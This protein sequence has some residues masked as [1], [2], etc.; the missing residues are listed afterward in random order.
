MKQILGILL[1]VLAVYLGY[2]GITAFQEST[3]EL[4]LFGLEIN[5]TD[6]SGKQTSI[7]YLVLAVVSAVGGIMLM[8]G[9]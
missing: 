3:A 8:K 7:I 6:E 9:N 1:I 4:N 2:M 5:A